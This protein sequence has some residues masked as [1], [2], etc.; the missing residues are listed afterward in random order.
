MLHTHEVTG[1]SPVVSTKKDTTHQGGVFFWWNK[2]LEPPRRE[3]IHAFHLQYHCVFAILH[4][5]MSMEKQNRKLPRLAGYDY[6]TPGVYFITICT[7]NKQC[8]FGTV[9]PTEF[10]G[11]ACVNHSPMGVIA[12]DCLLEIENHFPGIKV[13]NWVIMP[14]HIHILLR[15]EERIYPFPTADISNVIGKFKA[16]VTRKANCLHICPG[17][18][19]QSSFYDHIIRN[20]ADYQSIWQYISGNPSKWLED[21]FYVKNSV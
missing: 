19:W 15:V 12:R 20:E 3:C 13:D 17:K 10:V 11:E 6:A 9:C 1:S 21:Q 8:Y 18:L 16:A 4:M 2:G 14:N 7:L 5:V